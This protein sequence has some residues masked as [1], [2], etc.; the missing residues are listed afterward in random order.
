MAIKRAKAT[1]ARNARLADMAERRAALRAKFPEE[2][3]AFYRGD[4]MMR[5]FSLE[6]DEAEKRAVEK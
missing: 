5:A 1:A 4:S 3:D 6:A 2:M